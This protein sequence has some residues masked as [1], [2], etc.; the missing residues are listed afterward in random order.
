MGTAAEFEEFKIKKKLKG[1]A[2]LKKRVLMKL[3]YSETSNAEY[4]SSCR[5]ELPK[6]IRETPKNKNVQKTDP[7][8]RQIKIIHGGSEKTIQ[9][10][11]TLGSDVK[12]LVEKNT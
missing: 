8:N 4:F 12:S 1:F 3:Q 5:L 7:E 2:L 11:L 9:D 10:N 6:S